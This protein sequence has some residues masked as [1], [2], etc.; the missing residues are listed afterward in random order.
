[1]IAALPISA[2]L[3]PRRLRVRA[4]GRARPDRPEPAAAARRAPRVAARA[5]D[6]AAG[7]HGRRQPAG[8]RADPAR[9]DLCEARPVPGDAAGRGRRRARARPRDAAGQDGAVPAG[10]GRA[11]V[12]RAFGTPLRELVASLRSAGRRRVDRAGAP[13]RDRWPAGGRRPVA[14]KVLRPGIERRF[15]ADLDSF[16]F[17][18]RNAER[19]V[20]RS[21]AAAAGRGGRDACAARSRSRWTCGSKP[22]RSPRWRRTPRTIRISACRRSTGTCTARD[23]LTLEWIDGNAAVR[24]RRARGQGLRPPGARPRA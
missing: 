14:V 10:R 3:A 21:A 2:R 24:P 13:R 20:R 22:P 9:A 5:P 17:A 16:T 11:R 18:A 12:E 4:R 1:M 6:R 19:L 15:R 7:E 8:R 23:V